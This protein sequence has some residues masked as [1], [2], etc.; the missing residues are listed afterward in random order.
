MTVKKPGRLLE[1]DAAK[2]L[3]IFLVDLGH[4]VASQ[5]TPKGN[6]WY[7]AANSH[8][9]S[10]HMAFFFFLSGYVFFL[11]P[12]GDWPS[13]LRKS[14]SRLVPAYLLF[15]IIVYL[16]KLVAAHYVPVDRPV[17]DVF[18]ESWRMITYPTRGFA[19]FLW[20]IVTLLSLYGLMALIHQWVERYFALMLASSLALHLLSVHGAITELFGL[21]QLTRYWFFFLL[22]GWGL[23]HR[24]VVLPVIKRHALILMLALA[25]VLV[26]VPSPWLMTVAACV[27][28]PA[29]H[30]AVLWVDRVPPLDAVL[31][32]LGRNSYTIFLMN[33]L[34]L[35]LSRGVAVRVWGW[36]D[37]KFA[38]VAPVLAVCGL[39]LPVIAQR[40]VF[41]RSVYLDRLTR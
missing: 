3:A 32:W 31:Q 18:D 6:D 4:I 22:G 39:V 7:E 20:F 25:V 21:N 30:G 40:L 12:H 2:G 36:D 24:D 15:A 37:W 33:S 16:A 28:I 19:S 23:Q 38:V 34:A 26:Y 29:L 9:Y 13:R 8:L 14:L 10:F 35:G 5:N 11:T 1:I 17:S 27:A 41:S